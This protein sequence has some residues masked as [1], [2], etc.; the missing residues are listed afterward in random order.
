M[1][2]RFLTTRWSVVLAAGA[3]PSPRRRAALEELCASYWYPLYAFARRRG[4]ARDEAGDLVQGFFALLLE[5]DD[6]RLADP[7]R[8]RFRA[9]LA[10]AFHHFVVNERQKARAAKRGGGRA[11]AS[12]DVADAEARF[13]SDFAREESPERAFERAWAREVLARALQRLEA[14]QVHAQRGALFEALRPA[15]VAD[16]DA[17]AHAD[18]AQRLGTSENAVKVALHRLRKRFGELVR[19]EVSATLEDDADVDAELALLFEVLG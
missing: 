17:P 3:T 14:E 18:V 4:A 2:S 11:C 7:A 5:K 13:G 15:L 19:D 16:E 6:L 12:I 9:F 1:T 8:G 10:S